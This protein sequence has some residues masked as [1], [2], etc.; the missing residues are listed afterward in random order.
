MN[1]DN[2][3]F[4]QKNKFGKDLVKRL[5]KELGIV[6]ICVD[7]LIVTVRYKKEYTQKQ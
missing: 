7:K 6:P 5:C 4:E 1:S 3:I 2:F